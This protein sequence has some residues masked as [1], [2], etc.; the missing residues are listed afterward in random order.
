MMKVMLLLL[1]ISQISSFCLLLLLDVQIMLMNGFLIP[2][3]HFVCA[4]IEIGL[5]PIILQGGGFVKLGDDYLLDIVGIGSVQITMHDGIL[6]SLINMRHISEM[7]KN[8]I[9]LSTLDSKGYK[10]SGGDRV[11]KVSKGSLIMMKGELKS[12]NL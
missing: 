1:L 7:S 8:L 10:Y 6:R 5:S 11:L 9:S 2:L 12:P 3:F 4:Y